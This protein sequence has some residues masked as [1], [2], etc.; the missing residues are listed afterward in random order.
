VN[1]EHLVLLEGS[2][3]QIEMDQ[4][5]NNREMLIAHNQRQAIR[6]MVDK[7]DTHV[8][9][10]MMVDPAKH[11]REHMK[12]LL[13]ML[14]DCEIKLKN[15]D[16]ELNSLLLT[17]FAEYSEAYELAEEYS[18]RSKVLWY[19]LSYLIKQKDHSSDEG[20]KLEEGCDQ[21]L[22][23]KIPAVA[24]EKECREQVHLESFKNLKDNSAKRLSMSSV[25]YLQNQP[26]II[27]SGLIQNKEML[28]RSSLEKLHWST[29]VA[30]DQAE[31]SLE[32]FNEIPTIVSGV[33]L[34]CYAKHVMFFTTESSH[35]ISDA[36]QS[37]FGGIS[38]P[39][40][41]DKEGIIMDYQNK[42]PK[43]RITLK[44]ST[45]P[46]AREGIGTISQ[47]KNIL[48]TSHLYISDNPKILWKSECSAD[49]ER[50]Q[51]EV[52]QGFVEDNILVN[53]G[54]QRNS[55]RIQG[56]AEQL[57]IVIYIIIRYIYF[58]III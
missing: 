46:R 56:D 35:N 30:E 41:E 55:R 47:G 23:A 21:F 58:Q 11:S 20:T 25:T 5:L 39:V 48:I 2:Q 3:S 18:L 27:E 31:R 38:K 15:F 7:M 54:H 33:D 42:N 57:I 28:Q 50:Q 8:R 51:V 10:E 37:T 1:S 40:V 22:R 29:I 12:G 34:S 17:D 19:E 13:K 9:T 16:D 49:Q 44:S 43:F 53:F 24:A 36:A 52:Q 6:S 4:R 32:H 26:E 45:I 14:E